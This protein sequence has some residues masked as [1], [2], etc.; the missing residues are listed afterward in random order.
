[1]WKLISQIDVSSLNIPAS[2]SNSNFLRDLS[3]VTGTDFVGS[4]ATANTLGLARVYNV[5]LL[6]TCSEADNGDASCTAPRVGYWFNPGKDLKLASTTASQ[7]LL[8]PD[9]VTQLD[10][11]KKVAYFL[12]VAYMVSVGSLGMCLI[13]NVLSFCFPSTIVWSQV[14]AFVAT[15]FLLVASV[16]SI[17]K[18]GQLRDSFN[19][20]LGATGIQTTVGFQ[21]YIISFVAFGTGLIT[22]I[23]LA[24]HSRRRRARQLNN[25][26]ASRGL[27]TKGFVMVG[28]A[29]GGA[30]SPRPGILGRIPTWSRH[31]Y[32]E[33]GR[34]PQ[35]VEQRTTGPYDD[36]RGL[37]A[38]VE[39]DFSHEYPDD[40]AM[41]AMPAQVP[42]NKRDLNDRTTAYDPDRRE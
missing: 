25:Q 41:G 13:L 38:V 16:V 24:V 4:D 10:S 14:F 26:S 32:T 36:Q 31:K 6:A 11:Y 29:P 42:S 30:A 7:E 17:I 34:Q 2:L 27:D 28:G 20:T 23:F 40:I 19:T 22:F 39:D 8:S 5:S 21:V 35:L 9:Y 33:V 12:A 3:N 15:I 37:M 1:M 18:F